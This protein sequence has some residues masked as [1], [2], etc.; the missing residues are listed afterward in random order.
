MAHYSPESRPLCITPWVFLTSNPWSLAR[1]HSTLDEEDGGAAYQRWL[2]SGEGSGEDGESLAV[3]F[4][5]GSTSLVPG[6]G[7]AMNPGGGARRR[8]L[9]RPY[10]G[11]RAQSDCTGRFTEW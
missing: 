3:T 6:G 2:G 11:G 9:Y 10:H 5:Y 1:L 7:L 4:R 8:Y